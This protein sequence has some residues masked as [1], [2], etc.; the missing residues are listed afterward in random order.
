MGGIKIAIILSNTALDYLSILCIYIIL[1]KFKGHDCAEIGVLLSAVNPLSIVMCWLTL[2]LVLINFLLCAIILICTSILYEKDRKYLVLKSLLLGIV[3]CLSNYFR[4]AFTIALIA[5][6]IILLIRF[7]RDKNFIHIILVAT[8]VVVTN[9]PTMVINKAVNS[10]L[11]ERILGNSVGWS[12]YIGSNYSTKGKWNEEDR[13]YFFGEIIP[14]YTI[15]ESQNII[16]QEGIER[17]KEMSGTMLVSHLYNKLSVLYG[18][19]QN[20][21][22]DLK[23][24]FGVNQEGTS[25]KLLQSFVSIFF[26]ILAFVNLC[27]NIQSFKKDEPL[28]VLLKLLILGMT[29]AYL[30]VEVMNRYTFIMYPL[31]IMIASYYIVTILE[32]VKNNKVI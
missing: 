32:K 25:Y 8:M 30:I 4:P 16:K 2:N 28:L 1:N 6:A 31:M 19:Q 29:A 21:M 20:A 13:D 7:M 23:K 14:N 26:C 5:M 22:Y 12:F 24:A 3:I 15:E 18:D 10:Y 17:Y 11:N 9:V 27:F